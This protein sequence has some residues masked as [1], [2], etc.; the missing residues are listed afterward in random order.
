MGLNSMITYVIL[1]G[2]PLHYIDTYWI[3]KTVVVTHGLYSLYWQSPGSLISFNAQK[4]IIVI[5]EA[6]WKRQAPSKLPNDMISENK[7]A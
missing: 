4:L 3:A 1:Q 6:A 7:L 5:V 2:P